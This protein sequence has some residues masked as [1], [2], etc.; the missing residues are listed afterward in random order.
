MILCA[1][2]TPEIL[3]KEAPHVSWRWIE[4]APGANPPGYM[5]HDVEVAFS[6]LWSRIVHHKKLQS[7]IKFDGWL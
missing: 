3:V 1:S 2:R 4:G 6:Y 7:P 5:R